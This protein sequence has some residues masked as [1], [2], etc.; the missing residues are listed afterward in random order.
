MREI[1]VLW[2]G[3]HDREPWR[4]LCGEYADRIA[5]HWRIEQRQMRVRERDEAKRLAAEANAVLSTAPKGSTL[6]ALDS[7]GKSRSSEA[8]SRFLASTFEHSQGP[9][10]FV[11]G[12]D[13]GLHPEVQS[14]AHYKLS[15]GPMTLPHELARLVLLEQLYRALAIQ[16]GIK[17]HREP[18]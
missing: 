14:A 11:V 10:V 12:S 6:C 8:F 3:R 13:L 2:V 7:R 16:T 4:S 9:L 15:F 5:H 1:L 17:Y 18:F